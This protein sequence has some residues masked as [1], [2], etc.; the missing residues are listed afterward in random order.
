MFRDIKRKVSYL[1][2][3][4]CCCLVFSVWLFSKVVVW[5]DESPTDV[6]CPVHCCVVHNIEFLMSNL[7]VYFYLARFLNS[8]GKVVSSPAYLRKEMHNIFIV[9]NNFNS[10]VIDV[11]S[12]VLVVA[13]LSFQQEHE[14]VGHIIQFQFHQFHPKQ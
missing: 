10:L 8:A 2:S 5:V 14:L 7:I 9:V 12:P 3:N 6:R 4:L 11:Y 13:Q 1:G